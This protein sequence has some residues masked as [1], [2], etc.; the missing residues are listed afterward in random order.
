LQDFFVLVLDEEHEEEADFL[1]L[2]DLLE[3][4]EYWATAIDQNF[5]SCP[6]GQPAFCHK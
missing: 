6:L 2:Q 4:E 5:S 1:Q 3:H